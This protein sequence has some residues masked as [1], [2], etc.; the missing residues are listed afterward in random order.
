MVFQSCLTIAIVFSLPRLGSAQI[1]AQASKPQKVAQKMTEN[2]ILKKLV[3]KWAG[4]CRTWFEPEK[5]AD[6]SKV[7]GEFL[8]V[9]GG[10]F[11]RHVYQ[12]AMQG[13]PRSGENL[14]AFNSVAKLFESSWIDD[15]HMN[16]AILFSTGNATENGFSVRGNYVVGKDQPKWGWRT[17]FIFQ[18]DDH[19]TITA[20][21]ILPDGVEAKAVETKYHRIK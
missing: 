1:S 8:E 3:G 14:L 6:E 21:N 2:E 15:F 11:V 18:D 9:F 4:N 17:E 19:L 12:G 5:L 20:Y 7:S 13:K 16:Y 10:R